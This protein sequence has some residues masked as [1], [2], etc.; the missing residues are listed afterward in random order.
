M[1]ICFLKEHFT[2]QRVRKL[3]KKSI[4]E[5]SKHI[6][7]EKFHGFFSENTPVWPNFFF[8]TGP[9]AQA[10]HKQKSRTTKSPLMQDWVFR[11]GKIQNCCSG[12]HAQGIQKGVFLG[13]AIGFT[14]LQSRSQNFDNLCP[15]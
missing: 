2:Q 12:S 1:T 9:A 4:K 15:C 7:N 14:V 5:Q 8:S 3:L 13:K 6:K 10:A 11:L